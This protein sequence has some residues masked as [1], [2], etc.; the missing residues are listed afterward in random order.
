MSVLIDANDYTHN[1]STMNL[2]NFK[3]VI[4]IVLTHIQLSKWKASGAFRPQNPPPFGI[5]SRT[6]IKNIFMLFSHV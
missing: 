4:T 5:P 3:T 2:Q 6:L 1:I